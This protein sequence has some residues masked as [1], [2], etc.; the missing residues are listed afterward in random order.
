MVELVVPGAEAVRLRRRLTS[1]RWRVFFPVV[2]VFGDGVKLLLLRAAAGSVSSGRP[3]RSVVLLLV[4]G[5]DLFCSYVSFPFRVGDDGAG[6]G[7]LFRSLDSFLV[8]ADR[9]VSPIVLLVLGLSE[10]V[11]HFGFWGCGWLS[12]TALDGGCEVKSMWLTADV[13]LPSI[14]CSLTMLGVRQTIWIDQMGGCKI[15]RA[16]RQSQRQRR[17]SVRRRFLFQYC[18]DDGRCAPFVGCLAAEI[19]RGLV[20]CW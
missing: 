18:D 11:L 2:D 17:R 19:A 5:W 9:W 14:S 12:S 3:V 7:L 15:R 16:S 8:M 10:L 6:G 1:V 4:K 20:G 13:L